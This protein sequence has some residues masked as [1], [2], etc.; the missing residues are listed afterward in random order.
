M[1]ELSPYRSVVVVRNPGAMNIVSPK[2]RPSGNTYRCT[3]PGMRAA[4]KTRGMEFAT[5]SLKFFGKVGKCN[6][7]PI[8]V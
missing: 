8:L 6:S 5:R 1:S 7:P 2:Q 4:T 3:K